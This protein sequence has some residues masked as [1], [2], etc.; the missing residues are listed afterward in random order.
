MRFTV[1]GV[2]YTFQGSESLF[3]ADDLAS[4][5]IGGY[6]ALNAPFLRKRKYFSQ[7]ANTLPP[8]LSCETKIDNI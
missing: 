7:N 4:Q 1:H 5:Y 6:K 3:P 2:E 8:K